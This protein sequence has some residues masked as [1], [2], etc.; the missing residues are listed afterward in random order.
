MFC[1]LDVCYKSIVT[2]ALSQD[3]RKIVVRYFVNWAPDYLWL[4]L[5][6]WGSWV[7]RHSAS[8]CDSTSWERRPTLPTT[9][10][11]SRCSPGKTC[12]RTRRQ[13]L[14]A[15]EL[16]ELHSQ[17]SSHASYDTMHCSTFVAVQRMDVE[18]VFTFFKKFSHVFYV[19][20]V[21][22]IFQTFFYFKKKRWQSS[23]RQ[24]D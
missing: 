23:K 12:L 24:A 17:F 21:F 20:N 6:F 18:N 13:Q 4:R 3:N 14:T 15:D 8:Y 11:P 22:F 5:P 2:L 16:T 7:V 9:S 1:K 19:F 10:S